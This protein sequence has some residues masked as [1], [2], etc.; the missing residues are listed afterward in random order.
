MVMH[1]LDSASESNED[2]HVDDGVDDAVDDG[3]QS[4]SSFSSWH[5]PLASNLQALELQ[6]NDDT[7]SIASSQSFMMAYEVLE[8]DDTAS[9][10]PFQMVAN[11]KAVLLRFHFLTVKKIL[12]VDLIEL[13]QIDQHDKLLWFWIMRQ[14]VSKTD[15]I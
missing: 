3:A 10:S 6:S 12:S 8:N 7:M 9:M 1:D 15:W 14:N 2:E 4:S 5:L 11:T 13:F